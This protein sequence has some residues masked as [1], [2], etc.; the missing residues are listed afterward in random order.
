MAA[1]YFP[2][3]SHFMQFWR[4]GAP[5]YGESW[6]H[7][8]TVYIYIPLNSVDY[9]CA[10]DEHRCGDGTCIPESHV[11]DQDWDCDDLSDEQNC[12]EFFLLFLF[13]CLFL[14]LI[15]NWRK[16]PFKWILFGY[17]VLYIKYY[18]GRYCT[19]LQHIRV[20]SLDVAENLTS[21][22]HTNGCK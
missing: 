15:W 11:C 14:T 10:P 20:W 2:K 1:P 16:G 13:S 6:I 17:F 7:P 18:I 19:K 5:S 9:T 12:R 8:D 4:V 21:A 3:F 22:F